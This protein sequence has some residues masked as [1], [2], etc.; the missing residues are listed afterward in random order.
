MDGAGENQSHAQRF[1]QLLLGARV[2]RRL[3]QGE[4][5]TMAGLDGQR[6]A[7]VSNI[8][9]G[10]RPFADPRHVAMLLQSLHRQGSF[11]PQDLL[12]L[13]TAYLGL[14]VPE[15]PGQ[16]AR[17][18]VLIVGG[19]SFSGF[20]SQVVEAIARYAKGRYTII[21]EHHGE[22][23]KDELLILSA[24]EQHDSPPDALILAP[25]EGLDRPSPTALQNR[26]LAL[27]ALQERDVRLVV[28]DRKLSEGERSA[29]H[30]RLP[31]PY[32][33]LHHRDAGRQ[34]IRRLVQVH[35]HRRLG[36][37]LDCGHGVVQQERLQGMHEGITEARK[38][39]RPIDDP[40]IDYGE[41]N[42]RVDLEERHA[43]T[44]GLHNTRLAAARMLGLP[45]PPTALVC[46][47]SYV[48]I[49]AYLAATRDHQRAIPRDLSL[50]GFDYIPLMRAFEITRVPYLPAHLGYHA[51]RK[52]QQAHDGHP[53]A[54]K[55]YEWHV[56]D[57]DPRW[58]D[59]APGTI[60]PA[61]A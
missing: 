10:K 32:V 26:A 61:P 25:A 7:L 56:D 24:Y 40:F 34:A 58:T 2:S 18:L 48:T 46:S 60:G 8:E 3:T 53:D 43:P 20:W 19:V 29:L 12:A 51:I 21:L 16:S 31:A 17:T 4:L 38:S 30:Q 41:T 5:V 52:L 49:E 45:H 42:T 55:D 15:V 59:G 9:R 1:G 6:H 36:I 33:G 14:P 11:K 39:G 35:H 13:L 44:H 54:G 28:I 23:I 22:S 50:I 37:L 27:R 57:D 47:T